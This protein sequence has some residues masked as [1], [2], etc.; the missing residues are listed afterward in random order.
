MNIRNNRILRCVDFNQ[1]FKP[2]KENAKGKAI[3]NRKPWVNHAP[4]GVNVVRPNRVTIRKNDN[5]LS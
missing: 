2:Q 5:T 3:N 1:K 4:W